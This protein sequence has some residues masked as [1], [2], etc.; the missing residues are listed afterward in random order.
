MNDKTAYKEFHMTQDEVAK[1]LGVSREYIASIEKDAKI[2]AL[3]ILEKR[4]LKFD[5]LVGAMQ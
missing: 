3:K 2:K 5:D 1:V 4:G